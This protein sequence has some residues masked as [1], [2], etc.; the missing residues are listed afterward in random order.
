MPRRRWIWLLSQP[1]ASPAFLPARRRM[2]P[3]FFVASD[4]VSHEGL[5]DAIAYDADAS[6]Q[7]ARQPRLRQALR[8]PERPSSI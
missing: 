5:H 7:T 6:R 4:L 8:V 1:C 3:S 2:A